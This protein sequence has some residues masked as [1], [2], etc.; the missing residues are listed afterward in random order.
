M[1]LAFLVHRQW[2]P[3]AKWREASFRTLPSAAALAG[4]LQTLV[5]A[6]S[7]QDRERA[8]A[9]AA[10]LLLRVQR[11][12]GLPSPEAAAGMFW[13][14]PYRTID[15]QVTTLLMADVTDET[16]LRLP[17]GVGSVGQWIDCDPVLS[18]PENRAAAAAAFEA[19]LTA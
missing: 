2:A 4:P 10:D 3:Y 6:D 12:G 8:A 7:W 14:R 11:E 15:E 5:S 19:W 16:L 18:K 9:E 1:E 17:A 13:N